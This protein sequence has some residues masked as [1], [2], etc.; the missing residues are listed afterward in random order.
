[1]MYVT[2][3]CNCF[4]T[5]DRIY[6]LSGFDEHRLPIF[7][8]DYTISTEELSYRV[9]L[10]MLERM[11]H[12]DVLSIVDNSRRLLDAYLHGFRV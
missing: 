1:M 5:R 11:P 6:A 4:N 8:P 2:K 9:A 10:A 3:S 12:L 7:S